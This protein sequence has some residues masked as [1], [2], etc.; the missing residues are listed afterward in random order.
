MSLSE[1]KRCNQ[2]PRLAKLHVNKSSVQVQ[3]EGAR[4]GPWSSWAREEDA[5]SYPLLG[6]HHLAFCLSLQG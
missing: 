6:G 2:P 3:E 4:A 5:F 1:R